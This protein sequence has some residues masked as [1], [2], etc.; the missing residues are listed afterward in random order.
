MSRADLGKCFRRSHEDME[1]YLGKCLRRSLA[2]LVW[3]GESQMINT[4]SRDSPE[5]MGEPS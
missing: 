2:I 3:I 5:K 4:W 1:E